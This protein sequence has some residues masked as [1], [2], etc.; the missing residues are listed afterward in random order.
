MT[1][2]WLLSSACAGG[3]AKAAPAQM[4]YG[5]WAHPPPH[6]HHRRAC[7]RVCVHACVRA[8]VQDRAR[9]EL[10]LWPS[11]WVVLW[12]RGIRARMTKAFWFHPRPRPTRRNSCWVAPPYSDDTRKDSSS[13]HRRS[14]SL[15]AAI[16]A[17]ASMHPPTVA[18]VCGTDAF[19]HLILAWLRSACRSSVLPSLSTS[20][21]SPTSATHDTK[22]A[23]TGR[24]RGR[25]RAGHEGHST[26]WHRTAR[27]RIRTHHAPHIMHVALPQPARPNVALIS[28]ALSSHAAWDTYCAVLCCGAGAALWGRCCAV[29]Q[30]LSTC[31]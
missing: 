21:T 10:A 26:A 25:G 15:S 1:F 22:H 11:A 9:A 7:M 31:M 30:V 18:H 5:H 20:T 24:S 12:P 6:R 13:A 19:M 28:P 3:L 14:H 8:C 17:C 23:C 4:C 2:E 29:G 27:G 16:M